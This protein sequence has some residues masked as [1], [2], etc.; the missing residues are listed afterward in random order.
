ME[1]KILLLDAH[2]V[3]AISVARS[4][5]NS[6]YEVTG[7]MESK[8]SYGYVSRYIDHKIM[9]PKVLETS[10][11]YLSFLI[12]FLKRNPHEIIIP[13]YNNSAELLSKEKGKIEKETSA[14]CAI[15]DY[16]VFIKA[17]N[18]E[19]L[20]DTCEKY[21][22][23][24]PRTSFVDNNNVKEIASYVGFP[25]LIKPNISSG[26]KGIVLVNNENELCKKLPFVIKEFGRCTLQEFVDHTGIYYNV[27]LYR[28]K[29]GDCHE[30]VVIKISRYF[31]LKGGTS[32]YCETIES[33]QL[34]QMCKETLEALNW[35]GF[36]DFDIMED[37]TG[38]YKIIEINPRV[39]ASIH[40]AYIS[41]INYPEMIIA[42]LENREIRT[43]SNYYGKE[44]RF[45]GLDVMWFLFSPQRFSF[46]P[47]WFKFF[48]RNVFYQDGSWRDPLPMLMGCLQGVIK[49]MNPQFRKSKLIK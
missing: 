41:G 17:H 27:M 10:F 26:A 30:S 46:R 42:D 2:T 14:M 25:S 9:C 6:G 44:M 21:N 31:P 19:K 43:Y 39:P 40:A 11:E 23:P 32:C 47:S 48:G 29:K 5:K 20:M 8:L 16:D 36:A 49:Y 24:H 28:D 33:E 38:E 15:P 34:V 12:D 18:K 1:K 7:F 13:M 45:W 37:K 4:L 35:V 22:I 3:Q